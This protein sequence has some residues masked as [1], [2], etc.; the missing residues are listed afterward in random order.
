M[1]PFVAVDDLRDVGLK[2]S[3]K[4][5]S[6][7]SP[8]KR[9]R[10]EEEDRSDFE[11]EDEP[12]LLEDEYENGDAGLKDPLS[13]DDNAATST[14]CDNFEKVVKNPAEDIPVVS[15]S[16]D[17]DVKEEAEDIESDSEP[18]EKPEITE[19]REEISKVKLPRIYRCSLCPQIRFRM[20][21]VGFMQHMIFHNGLVSRIVYAFKE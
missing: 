2:T 15:E 16:C 18:E 12:W 6:V 5:L 11:D 19:E 13:C 7:R 14:S 9:R 8:R 20:N 4:H 3:K 21:V 10:V 17:D 1:A